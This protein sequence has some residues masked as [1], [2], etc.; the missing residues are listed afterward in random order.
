VFSD[1]ISLGKNSRPGQLVGCR[2]SGVESLEEIL[3][4]RRVKLPR[5]QSFRVPLLSFA[6]N[7][8]DEGMKKV[9]K[10]YR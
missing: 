3:S 1:I 4:Q 5:H 7:S 9:L 10:G 2:D 6:I 8:S